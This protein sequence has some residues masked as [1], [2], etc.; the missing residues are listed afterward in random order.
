MLHIYVF[1]DYSKRL[2]PTVGGGP[3]PLCVVCGDLKGTGPDS[4]VCTAWDYA[5]LL[6]N[7]YSLALE[8]PRKSGQN[9]ALNSQ[10]SRVHPL[11]LPFPTQPT[12]SYVLTSC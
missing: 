8:R 4:S 9:A 11:N 5:C 12:S 6:W 10:T 3:F 1:L 7:L 2:F